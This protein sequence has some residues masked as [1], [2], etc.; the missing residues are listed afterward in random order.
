MTSRPN[1][2]VLQLVTTSLTCSVAAAQF[3]EIRTLTEV[4]SSVA[5]DSIALDLDRDGHLDLL[6][7]SAKNGE[8]VFYRGLG[9]GDFAAPLLLDSGVGGVSGLGVLDVDGDGDKDPVL[10][11]TGN[12]AIQWYEQVSNGRFSAA[13]VLVTVPQLTDGFACADLD[14][15]QDSDLVIVNS[16]TGRVDWLENMLPVT[17]SAIP[18]VIGQLAGAGSVEVEDLDGDGD[19]DVYVYST[20]RLAAFESLSG[21]VSWVR[22]PGNQALYEDLTSVR[23]GDVDGDGAIDL[24]VVADYSGE[25]QLSLH[26]N[27]GASFAPRTQIVRENHAK[28]AMLYDTDGDGLH[29]LLVGRESVA[30][31]QGAVLAL[32]NHGG[33]VFGPLWVSTSYAASANR[34][35]AVDLDA[36]GVDDV[37]CTSRFESTPVGRLMNDGAGN[38]A[39]FR[40]ISSSGAI[41]P[42]DSVFVD[43]DGDGVRDLLVASYRPGGLVGVPNPGSLA[44]Y[45]GMGGGRFG[46][47]G[48]IPIAGVQTYDVVAEDLDGDGDPDLVT[49][50][51][52]TEVRENLGGGR[53][54]TR[55]NLDTGQQNR[56]VAAGDLN[57]DGLADIVVSAGNVGVM[58][59]P[60]QGGM[61]FGAA[62]QLPGTGPSLGVDVEDMDGDGDK[63]VLFIQISPSQ[64]KWSENLG[65]GAFGPP[66]VLAGANELFQEPK[67]ITARDM[68]ADGVMDVVAG[69]WRSTFF[70]RGL[71]GGSFM[72]AERVA[73][74][75]A[76]DLKDFGIGD[77]DG[78]GSLDIVVKAFLPGGASFPIRWS[79]NLGGG[80]FAATQSLTDNAEQPEFL[81]L[82]DVDGDGD[83]DVLFGSRSDDEVRWIENLV[84]G[85][86]FPE[87]IGAAFCGPAPVNSTGGSARM[88]AEGSDRVAD[89]DI[90]L[91]ANGLPAQAFGLFFRGRHLGFDPLLAGGEGNL[92]LGSP[93]GRF[94][95]SVQNA[96]DE[97]VMAHRIDMQSIPLS[98]N[99][100]AQPG[101]TWYFQAWYRDNNS[102][103]TSNLTDGLAITLR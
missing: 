66:Q 58:W 61:V 69:G 10:L 78:D 20:T 94:L 50:G 59:F 56:D 52:P 6:T 24:M 49:S 30:T 71:R 22:F 82:D 72:A 92:C 9:G 43:F 41:A 40:T 67:E 48:H 14:G 13:H 33:G 8:L 81:V 65:G 18:Q 51:R 3:G 38:W 89:G 53:F 60:N 103:A 70:V 63:D 55:I 76:W 75:P 80:V 23:A 7:A 37:V 68:D 46:L 73:E 11:S 25:R 77:V 91:L 45:P 2:A 4:R 86:L 34:L 96:T 16:A 29:E 57:G 32:E 54:G 83:D 17:F 5:V 26:R 101:E 27:L 79:R 36:D 87:R 31:G 93:L 47:A 44:W 84:A 42:K 74:L 12:A 85:S 99:V 62:L 39:P 88:A 97:G 90:T 21:G 35:L 98:L 28:D 100:S 64:A 102:G 19:T 15:D 1:L 95:N